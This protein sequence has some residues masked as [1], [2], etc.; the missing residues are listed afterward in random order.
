MTTY[1]TERVALATLKPWPRNYNRHPDRQIALLKQSLQTF[2]Q[3]KNIVVYRDQIVA[4]HGLAEAARALG[5]TTIAVHRLPSDWTSAQVEALLVADNRIAELSDPDLALLS[6]IIDATTAADA[7][8]AAVMGYNSDD[9]AQLLRALHVPDAPE[10]F[11]S[12][13][14]AS[15]ETEH[16]CPRCNFRWA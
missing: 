8:L 13:D 9:V 14:E 12:Y 4:G 11:R 10:E 1:T 3:V 5:W 2:G 15:I 16:T 7:D 6:E